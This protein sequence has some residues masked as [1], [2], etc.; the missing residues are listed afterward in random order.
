M[1]SKSILI[2][3]A[4]T[5]ALASDGRVTVPLDGTWDI[6]ESVAA[7]DVPKSFGH[8]GPVP[9][10][11]NLARPVF[12]AVDRFDSRESMH[13]P[14]VKNPNVT[15]EALEAPVGIP[16]QNRNYFWYRT[17]FRAPQKKAVAV[18]KIN[19]A[20]FGTAVWLNGRM[21]GAHLGCFSAGFFDL[22]QGMDWNGENTLVV[23]IGAHPAAL[24][25]TVPAGTDLEKFKWTPGIYDSVSL[26]LSDNPV[27]ETVQ[28]APRIRSS[29]IVVQ[30]SIRN[31]SD[32]PVTFSLVARVRTAKEQRPVADARMPMLSLQ[33]G[34][35]RTWTQTIRI[36]NATLWSPENPFLYQL[37]TSTG[38]D[39]V[40][41]RFGMREFRFDTATRRAYLNGQVY[42]LRGSNIT[43]HR[44]FEDPDCGSLP[45]Q[46][47]W[48]RKLLVEIPKRMHW[49]S[50][51]FCIGP[52][53]DRWLEIADEA[54]LLIQNEFP[55]WP[56]HEQWDTGEVVR[57][58]SEWM[59]D[60]WNHPSVAIWDANNETVEPLFAKTIIPSVRALDLSNR[61]WD[62][63]W[64]PPEGPDDPVEHHPY[65]AGEKFRMAD[66]EH[67]NGESPDPRAAHGR[68]SIIN[69]YEWL[70]LNRDGSPTSLTK[71]IYDALLGPNA[72][73]DARFE[74]YAY[75]L[76]GITEFWR[77]HRSFAG[78][79][80][81][82]YLTASF[83]GAY[84]S[85]NFRDVK[86]LEL[87]PHFE[88][89][90]REAFKPLGVYVDFWQPEARAG[91]EETFKVLVVNDARDTASGTLVLTLE[92]ETGE[93]VAR[94]ETAMNVLPNGQQTFLMTLRFPPA[95]GSYVL[96]AVAQA[97]GAPEPTVS[98]RKLKTIS[99]Q[100]R[101]GA[102]KN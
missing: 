53:P 26:L 51:R 63:G 76:A 45:W 67:M 64:N 42:F 59:R 96:K 27:I 100:R 31:H 92:S 83:P 43:L 8:R 15:K 74:E 55:I 57:Q 11:A 32:R 66:L 98:R 78:V 37:E 19:K 1:I 93:S 86:T 77:A 40:L 38:G 82:T 73:A 23:R 46:E 69:E 90:M 34:E 102:E 9:G 2:V 25:V 4:A 10:L 50:F 85:D 99:P 20:Q 71:G 88:K 95:S 39:S 35:E 28:V 29:E 80:Y 91:A 47:P 6:E 54:G 22:T 79:Q 18:L 58:F 87:E 48:V 68:A 81:F 56:Y 36:S 101:G 89:Y 13:H 75:E 61:P 65:L 30:T 62:N 5:S 41:T 49:N 94:T 17:T 52:V 97:D 21:I 60:N 44:F 16:R 33:G 7:E 14:H 84:T 12:A 70:W 3:A 24:P 72:T